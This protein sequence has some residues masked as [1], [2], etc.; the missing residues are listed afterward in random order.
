MKRLIRAV[1]G[2]VLHSPVELPPGVHLMQGRLIPWI[3]GMFTG[4]RRP[5]AA[6]TVGDT[7]VVHP[8]AALSRG[9]VRHELEHVRQWR[10]EGWL[11]PM[12]YAWRYVRHGYR[13]N[14]YEVAARAAEQEPK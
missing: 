11:F 10:D 8:D 13:A 5:A 14:P 12:R 4:S 2:D 9:L 7:I 3:G 1:S 6:V